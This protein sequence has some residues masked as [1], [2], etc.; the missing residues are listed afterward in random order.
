[1]NLPSGFDLEA[2]RGGRDSR[3]ENTLP[4]FAYALAIGVTTLETDAQITADGV[5]V[6]SHNRNVPWYMA[7]SSSG[8][9]IVADQQPD[10]PFWTL[11][12]L[13]GFDLGAMSPNAP[14]GYWDA[15]GRTQKQ[16]PGTRITT[17]EE[18]FQLIKAWGNDKVFVNIETKSLAYPVVVGNPNPEE[19]VSKIYDLAVKYGMEDRVM[20]QSFDW[21]TLVQMKKVDP[22]VATVALTAN[23]PSWN[24]EG[25]EGD[26]QWPNRSKP[27][28]W[29]AGL[30]IKDFGGDAVKAARKIG[31][32]VFAPYEEEVN[33]R[34]VSQAHGLGMQVVPYTVNE[35]KRMRELIRMGVDGI[36]TDRP[37]TLRRIC[38]QLGV[39]VPSPDP[40]PRNKPHYSG[41]D[42]L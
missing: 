2:H 17:L 12:Q 38:E 26:Y 8:R 15:H 29:M 9:F 27:S 35:P 16:V 3:P 13:K 5:V 18:L 25:D 33:R 28:P 23:Q 20:I 10:I 39:P 42:G 31:A 1:M 24:E 6:L 4:A 41:V 7:K 22:R 11:E 30:D 40:A 14:F 37:A 21:R 36:I 34:V 19:W 32:D